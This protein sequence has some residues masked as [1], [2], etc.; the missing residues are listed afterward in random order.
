MDKQTMID[1]LEGIQGAA[2]SA[3]AEDGEIANESELSFIERMA[4]DVLAELGATDVQQAEEPEAYQYAIMMKNE[5]TRIVDAAD[6][7]TMKRAHDQG[8]HI[9]AQGKAAVSAHDMQ[10]GEQLECED[11]YFGL[12]KRIDKALDAL[13]GLV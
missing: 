8:W 10:H 11:R 7:Q 9:V 6:S 5:Y 2:L 4:S 13:N 1:K 3:L 12:R